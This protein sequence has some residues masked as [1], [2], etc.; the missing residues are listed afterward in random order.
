VKARWVRTEE[1]TPGNISA[2]D[3]F[4]PYSFV[5]LIGKGAIL[6][7]KTIQFLKNRNVSW[8][9]IEAES[10]AFEENI[11]LSVESN[12]IDNTNEILVP[13]LPLI[14][15]DEKYHVSLDRFHDFASVILET[16]VGNLDEVEDISNEIVSEIV[17]AEP[18]ILNFM[19]DIAPGFVVKHGINC[20]IL[21]AAI[22]HRLKQPWH[23]L[24]QIVKVALLHDIGLI[25]AT[26]EKSLF[27]IENVLKQFSVTPVDRVRYHPFLS[28]KLIERIKPDFF[29]MDVS[30]GIIHHHERFD[31]KGFPLGIKGKNINFFSRVLAVA[32]AYDTLITKVDGKAILDPYHAL[33]WIIHNVKSIFDPDIVRT[34]VE[35]AGLY[36]TGTVVRLSDGRIGSVISKGEKSIGRPILSVENEEVETEHEEGIYIVEVMG[37][38]QMEAHK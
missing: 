33:K 29:E 6:D 7:S 1:V 10:E 9:P 32:D 35:I 24:V 19:N 25:H 30:R 11:P 34:F 3:V 14:L 5:L 12:V 18:T 28:V 31:G 27:Y 15:S 4:D 21:A 2:E 16:G 37:I 20:A 22:G 13:D 38:D 26:K 36:P 23:F 17:K 8:V